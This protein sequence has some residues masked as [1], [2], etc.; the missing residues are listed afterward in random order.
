MTPVHIDRSIHQ[1][2]KLKLFLCL[3]FFLLLYSVQGDSYVAG[4]WQQSAYITYPSA[5]TT[6][7]QGL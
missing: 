6:S 3:A 4:R 2:E 7:S 1:S 5:T